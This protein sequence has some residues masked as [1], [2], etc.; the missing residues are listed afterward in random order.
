MTTRAGLVHVQELVVALAVLDREQPGTGSTRRQPAPR[1][2]RA[3]PSGGRPG[4]VEAAYDERDP[5]MTEVEQVVDGLAHPVRVAGL[6]RAGP[7]LIGQV[8]IEEH[9]GAELAS[10]SSRAG[11]FSPTG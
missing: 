9:D 1:S 3:S 8:A 2:P 10:C 6:D 4:D 5:T 7:E 11:S